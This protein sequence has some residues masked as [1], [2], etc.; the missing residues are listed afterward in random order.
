[1]SR[2]TGGRCLWIVDS[3]NPLISEA[4]GT[5]AGPKPDSRARTGGGGPC[6]AL[7]MAA[8]PTGTVTFL[9]TDIESSTHL[10]ERSPDAMRSALARDDDIVRRAIDA[11][12]GYVFS[13]GGDG[14]A[15]AF[16]RTT[17][18]VEA[19]A[20]AQRALEAQVWPDDIRLRIRIGIHTG[21]CTE[22]DGDYFGSA[23]NRAARL[24]GIAHGGQTVMSSAV[25]EILPPDVP[26][27]DLGEHRL[28]D[29]AQPEHVFQ[30]CDPG[31]DFEFPPLRSLEA[32]PT[33]L[34]VQ[35]TEFVGR[36]VEMAELEKALAES[37]MVT[38][39]G[40]GGVGKTRLAVQV[41][42]D[43][44]PSFPDGAWIA[45]LGGTRDAAAIEEAACTALGVPQQPGEAIRESLTS[46]LHNKR[47]LLVLDNCE[48]LLDPA[49]KLADEIL[50]RAQGVTVLATSRE[51]LRVGGE[52]VVAVPSLG[53]PDE[54]ALALAQAE[55]DAVHLFVQ[56]AQ[57]ARSGFSLNQD[58]AQAVFQLCRRLD[59]IPLAIELAAARVRSM[60]PSEIAAR[61]DQRLR[62]LTGG[63]RTAVDRHQTLRRAIDWSYDLLEPEERTLLGRLAVCAGGLDLAAAEE[64][65]SG[66]S[67]DSLDVDDLLGRLVDKSLVTSVDMGDTTRYRMLET[68]REYALERFEATGETAQ[69]R[70]RHAGHYALFA[71]QAG[72]GLK[73]PDER[74]WLKAVEE[75]L[76]NLRTAVD[77]SLASE[78]AEAALTIIAAL[79]LQGLRIKRSISSWAAM[80]V[81]SPKAQSLSSFPVALAV[82]GWWRMNEGR[83]DEAVGLLE[84]ALKGLDRGEEGEANLLLGVPG[85]LA[86]GRRVD[87]GRT[88]PP[89]ARA[90][91]A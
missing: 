55:S 56:R 24:M 36:G 9:F 12:G 72:Q 74:T 5:E 82:H 50:R 47:L 3:Q 60:A 34:P 40:V 8:A 61:L 13:T 88:Q 33:N 30:L 87:D 10:W 52:H 35:S 38:L 63:A 17:S 28:R 75:E 20:I 90:T 18:A 67:I 44:L 89:A 69:M 29:L 31:S 4:S 81:D 68:V 59:G 86:C 42:A 41:A 91:V 77:W 43:V 58:N 62:L 85:P 15:A 1:M 32:Y 37:R 45:E 64:M 23:V 70:G 49:S 78:G 79:G 66:G 27:L 51:P 46:F 39:T 48:H 26:V 83:L 7:V 71:T 19:A 53:L 11:N 6:E 73:G 65:G 22:R 76:D 16:Q 57:S 80:A 2:D 84:E 14:F 54:D 21:E 25:Q